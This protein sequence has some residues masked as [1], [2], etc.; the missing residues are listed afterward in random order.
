SP[1][2]FYISLVVGYV[3][4]PRRVRGLHPHA[5][6]DAQDLERVRRIAW[7]EADRTRERSDQ[8]TVAAHLVRAA[9]E[10]DPHGLTRRRRDDLM[11]RG[12]IDDVEVANARGH[13]GVSVVVA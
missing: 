11:F 2:Y 8:R 12:Q 1:V 7:A 5:A 4:R 3:E 6:P 9:H 13:A 10:R